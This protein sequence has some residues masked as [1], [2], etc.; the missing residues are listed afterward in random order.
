MNIFLIQILQ[1]SHSLWWREEGWIKLCIVKKE[2]VQ[3]YL[4]LKFKFHWAVFILKFQFA[5][6]D[7]I[8]HIW[9]YCFLKSENGED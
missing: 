2:E 1:S 6:V 3:F 8:V 9:I 5:A 4:K 7:A